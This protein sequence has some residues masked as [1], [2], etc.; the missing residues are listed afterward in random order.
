[1]DM[2]KRY[3]ELLRDRSSTNNLHLRTGEA[4]TSPTPTGGGLVR[5][6]IFD[7]LPTNVYHVIMPTV[8]TG[9]VGFNKL[10]LTRDS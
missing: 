4:L 10:P 9:S 7:L 3:V 2:G 1:M 8:P 6:E 5:D